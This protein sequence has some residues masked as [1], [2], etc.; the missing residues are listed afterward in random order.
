MTSVP[1]ETNLEGSWLPL[2]DYSGKY[3][4]SVSTLRRRI[5]AEDIKF[6]LDDGKYFI[7]DEPMSTHQRIHRP[8]PDSDL[9]DVGTHQG[10]TS[11]KPTGPSLHAAATHDEAH[12]A[13][14]DKTDIS[15]KI[16]KAKNDEPI[17]TAANKLLT[18]LKRA[19]TV[20]LQEKEEQILYLK[21]EVSD[22]KTLVRVLDSENARLRSR[23]E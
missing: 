12:I 2:M 17:L 18:E 9:A 14:A 3:K 10:S 15:D 6:R 22:L 11:P 16:A 4:V 23:E 13:L 5:K 1:N 21:E 7:I 19:Y 20:I 8:S